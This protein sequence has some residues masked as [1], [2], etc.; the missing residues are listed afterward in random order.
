MNDPIDKD[1]DLEHAPIGAIVITT[2][3]AVIIVTLWLAMYVINVA[4]S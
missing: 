2:L 4:R 3:I 1:E